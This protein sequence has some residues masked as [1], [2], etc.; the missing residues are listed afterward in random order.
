MPKESDFLL[1]S[2]QYD[3][4]ESQIAQNPVQPP[5]S[6]KLMVFDRADES[7]DHRIFADLPG[8]LK[9]GDTLFFNDSRVLPA[10]IVRDDFMITRPS[11]VTRE[12]GA[13]LLYLRLHDETHFE[14]MVFP[15]D[16]FP[17]GT[18]VALG[19]YRFRVDAITY[20]GRTFELLDGE[21]IMSFLMEYG[22]L[23]LP[24]YIEYDDEKVPMYQ[25]VFAKHDGSLAAP[26]ASLH[27]SE[28]LLSDLDQ[29]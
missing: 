26:T 16:Y 14:S 4:P 17:V 8:I 1:T 10:R 13:E 2:Y 9:S 3:L 25:T 23:P 5:E 15:G 27:F 18:V 21:N 19:K 20:E 6:A 28:K 24:P 29:V 7:V 12:R 22:R 11:G